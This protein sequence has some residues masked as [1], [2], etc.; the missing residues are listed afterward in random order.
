MKLFL[1][2]FVEFEKNDKI[3]S[4]RYTS[5]CAVKKPDTWPIMMIIYNKSIFFAND[6]PQKI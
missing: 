3:L 4:K 2:Y 1:S 5:D 6:I